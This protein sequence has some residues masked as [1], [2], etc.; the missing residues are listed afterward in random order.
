MAE[1]KWTV[2]GKGSH[3]RIYCDG[4]LV[5]YIEKRS[6]ETVQIRARGSQVTIDKVT[7]SYWVGTLADGRVV[8]EKESGDTAGL[9]TIKQW[10]KPYYWSDNAR[11]SPI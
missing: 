8:R 1:Q 3:R 11:T 2:R 4:L 9:S 6:E 7:Q 5:G 10:L